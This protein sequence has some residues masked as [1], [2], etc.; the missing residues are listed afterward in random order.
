M[1]A[2]GQA[3]L[4]VP[5]PL[6]AHRMQTRGYNQAALLAD[7]LGNRIGVE[8]QL[9]GLARMRETPAQVAL[10]WAERYANVAGAFKAAPESVAGKVIALVDDVCTTGGSTIQAIEAARE[11]G[12]EVLGAICLVDREQGG[13]E[14]I[15]QEHRCPFARIFAMSELVDR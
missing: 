4:L 11:A 14:A 13:R 6:A 15:E 12:M 2:G 7:A 3:D 9:A 8:R 10:G 5:V 1:A